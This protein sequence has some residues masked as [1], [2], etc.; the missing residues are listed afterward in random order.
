ML[1][2]RLHTR[3]RLTV[4]GMNSGT[5]IDSVDLALIE[6]SRREKNCTCR[7]MSGTEKKYPAVLRDRLLAAAESDTIPFEEL[8]SLDHELGLF[9]G[10][11][12][13]QF[14][15]RM[16]NKRV[17]VDL[18]ASHGQTIQHL[19]GRIALGGKPAHATLQIGSLERIAAQTGR[20]TI[21]DFRQADIALGG[22]GAPITVGAMH[23]LFGDKKETRL[24]VNIGGIANFFYFPA[25]SSLKSVQAADCGPGNLLSDLLCRKLFDKPFDTDGALARAGQVS[26]R[27]L[28]LLLAH[29]FFTGH[30]DISTGRESFGPELADHIVALGSEL[31]LSP[32]D[33]L[34]TA[35][36]LT[37]EGIIASLAHLKP[38]SPPARKLYLT[39]GGARNRFFLRGLHD[40]LPEMKV[41]RIDTLGIR[42]GLVEAAAYAVMGEA[43]LRGE[44]L[45]AA[46]TGSRTDAHPI[47]GKIAQPPL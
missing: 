15:T 8:T 37:T 40:R 14:I 7:Y 2:S 28:S 39:G 42:A 10:R 33:I 19:P 44:S 36:Q 29:P 46:V 9:M 25:G 41:E 18:V 17:T 34:A 45:A 12:A 4:L 26:R 31:S 5:S 20:V 35:A 43:C 30:S 6:I 22:E 38:A 21:G 27:L 16:S 11:T 3:R 23:R 13:R 1:L 32:H 47:L 24:I